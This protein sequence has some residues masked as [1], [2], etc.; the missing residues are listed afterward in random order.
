MLLRNEGTDLMR[1]MEIARFT[2]ADG[3]FTDI[4]LNAVNINSPATGA[5][6]I[7]DTSPGN[8]SIA[9]TQTLTLTASIGTIADAN[10]IASALAFQWQ[11]FNGTTWANVPAGGGSNTASYTPQDI[12]TEG[13][14]NQP[15]R[16]QVSFT[17][18]LGNPEVVFS[19]PTDPLGNFNNLVAGAGPTNGTAGADIFNP[20]TIVV[21]LSGNNLINGLAGDDVINGGAGNDTLNGGDGADV[22]NGGLG[23]DVLNGGNGNDTMLGGGGVDTLT[24][25]AGVDT[26]T[27]NGGA[28]TFFFLATSD[29]GV[30][31]G[32]RDIITDFVS[33]SDVINLAGIDANINVAGDQ[34]FTVTAGGGAGAFTN[35]AGQIRAGLVG[36]NVIIEGDVNG[37]GLADFQIQLGNVA[38][39]PADFVF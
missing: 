6:A 4:T 26:M 33:G 28:D 10:G 19:A 22:L 13:I 25:G 16:A 17:D 20:L 5:P 2:N 39:V 23:T 32:A 37:D 24:G 9:P 38:L 8:P 1:N 15:L 35:V 27:G 29:S 12:I 3:S 30:G 11:T 7:A 21:D 14:L 18:S 31:A 34:A 36:A